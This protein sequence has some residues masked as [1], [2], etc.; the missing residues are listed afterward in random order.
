MLTYLV[1]HTQAPPLSAYN[2]DRKDPHFPGKQTEAMEEKQAETSNEPRGYCKGRGWT[3]NGHLL[4]GLWGGLGQ[5]LFF[6]SS[7]GTSNILGTALQD[8][9][10]GVW[11]LIFIFNVTGFRITVEI[12]LLVHL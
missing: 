9:K 3:S 2:L 12:H 7:S 11:W 10:V 1:P 6:Q 5:S 4:W 8:G